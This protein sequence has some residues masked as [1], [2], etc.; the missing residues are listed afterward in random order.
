[1][2][3]LPAQK[4]D[5]NRNLRYWY[6]Y[7][8]LGAGFLVYS[9][10]VYKAEVPA[11]ATQAPLRQVTEGKLLWQKHNCSSCHQLYGLGGYLGPDL[12]NTLSAKG[13][14]PAYAAAILKSG[15]QVMPDFKLSNTEIASLLAFLEHVD[16]SGRGSVHDFVVTPGGSI[17]PKLV[18]V[19]P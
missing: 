11:S 8:L 10:F 17:A 2:A 3:A 9:G 18:E 6:T 1:M 15:T 7:A 5:K 13:K 19:A 12:T 4:P 14:G 16:N